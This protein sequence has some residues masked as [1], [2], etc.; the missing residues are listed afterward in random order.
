MSERLQSWSA[1]TE[2]PLP[3]IDLTLEALAQ[4]VVLEAALDHAPLLREL[5]R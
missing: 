1:P 5:G 2:Q 4:R 3:P